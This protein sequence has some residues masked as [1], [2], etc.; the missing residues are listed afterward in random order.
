MRERMNDIVARHSSLKAQEQKEKALFRAR[1]EVEINANGTSG[2][3]I[4]RG[5]QRGKVLKHIR[6]EPRQ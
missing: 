1:Q 4:K 2:Y 3:T 6:I 5:A